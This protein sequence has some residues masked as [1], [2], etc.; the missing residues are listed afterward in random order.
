MSVRKHLSNIY[1]QIAVA[2]LTTAIVIIAVNAVIWVM[3]R[4]KTPSDPR[5][6]ILAEYRKNWAHEVPDQAIVR[7]TDRVREIYPNLSLNQIA[8]L[9]LETHAVK[10]MYEEY[11]QFRERP[12]SGRFVN[13]SPAGFRTIDDQ[14][15]WPA[16][17]RTF[18]VFVFGGS[19]AFGYG[20]EDD[21]TVAAHLQKQLNSLQQ[22]N[23]CK[24]YNFGRAYYHSLQEFVL[25]G[26][27]LSEGA[28]P[29]LVV[30]LDGLNECFREESSRLAYTERIA[31]TVNEVPTVPGALRDFARALPLWHA[32]RESS[33]V[34]SLRGIRP[35]APPSDEATAAQAAKNVELYRRNKLMIE[36]LCS[37]ARVK[38]AFVWQPV[39]VYK[40]DINPHV[41]KDLF[42]ATYI[43]IL[44]TLYT[45]MRSEF[46]KGSL[47]DDFIW[48]ADIQEGVH[49]P[50]YVSRH[51]YTSEMADMIA[52]FIAKKLVA[53]DLIRK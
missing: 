31:Q 25:L 51:H 38:T 42:D 47:G 53:T 4:E 9:I 40:S 12:C 10:L 21:G 13:V 34:R 24:V 8:A 11:T 28:K 22:R 35:K 32:I 27:L 44:T 52:A 29:D 26:K 18:T 20:V 33:L 5:E 1:V 46:D 30:F 15:P 49:K 37:T 19:T 41:F 50:L 14:G 6:I 43:K 2:V 36:G 39:P 3:L 23:V 45:A 16:D 17:R 7:M 48:A